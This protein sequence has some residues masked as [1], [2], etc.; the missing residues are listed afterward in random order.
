MSR[1][2]ALLLECSTHIA[3]QI[4]LPA[5][6]DEAVVADLARF[7]LECEGQ[8]GDW[9]VNVAFVSED[10]IVRLHHQFL[11][12]PAPTDIITFPHDEGDGCGGDIAICVAVAAAQGVEHSKSLSEE[13][14]FLVLHGV[15]HLTGHDDENAVSRAAMLARQQELYD[16]WLAVSR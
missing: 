3:G 10:E 9:T 16:A 2:P 13:L 5:S 11:A 14:L 6:V 1:T 8:A 7:A 12:D 15:L 4:C